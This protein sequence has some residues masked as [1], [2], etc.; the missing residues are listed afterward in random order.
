VSPPRILYVTGKGGVGK[1]TV[2]AAI[3]RQAAERGLRTIVAEPGGAA[4]LP[5]LFGVEG[6]GYTPTPLAPN[7]FSISITPEEAM[8]EYVVQ[9]V[10]FRRLYRMVFRNRVMGPFVDGVP[11]LHDGVT[12]GKVF[13]LER[14]AASGRR[15]WDLILVD[16]PATG[17]GLSLLSS[18]RAMMS[19]TRVGPLYEGNRMVD[20]RISDPDVTGIVL[21]ALPEELPVSETL[22]L[23]SALGDRRRQVRLCVLNQCIPAPI[24]SGV[25]W[26]DAREGVLGATEAGPELAALMDALVYQHEQQSRAAERL[27]ASLP[28]PVIPL[29]ALTAPL[30]SP[31]ELDV[32]GEPLAAA[33]LDV[34]RVR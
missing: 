8:E 3:A 7:L 14:S 13:D 32:L 22:E 4:R 29:P 18:A 21:V 16:A 20:E 25:V 15:T 26:E 2:T 10:R 33:L 11:G 28:V 34:E 9:Q 31:L 19:L 6:Q 1:T 5:S 12:L 23:W 27:E 17:H 30:L 24:P